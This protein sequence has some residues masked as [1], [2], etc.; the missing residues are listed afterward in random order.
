[1]VVRTR[2][3]K[4]HSYRHQDGGAMIL[5]SDVYYVVT[6]RLLQHAKIIQIGVS[7]IACMPPRQGRSLLF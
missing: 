7:A 1:M 3:A 6:R 5:A 4:S 2:N